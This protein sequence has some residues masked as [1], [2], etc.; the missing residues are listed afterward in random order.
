LNPGAAGVN[1]DG[2]INSGVAGATA[3]IDGGKDTVTVAGSLNQNVTGEGTIFLT[4][5]GT[6]TINGEVD[7]L[8]GGAGDDQ[9]A[10][11][12][13]LHLTN[14]SVGVVNGAGDILDGGDGN[15]TIYGDAVI[16]AS[17]S[18][19]TIN[20]G[21]DSVHGGNGDDLIY[22]EGAPISTSDAI[23][24]IIGGNDI[25]FGDAGNDTIYGQSGNDQLFGGEGDD[26]L[27]GG[28]GNYLLCGGSGTN[29][30]KGGS[31]SDLR[32]AVDDN[33]QVTARGGTLNVSVNE[34]LDDESEGDRDGRRYQILSIS[35]N[36][37]A[38]IDEK[39]GRLT[40]ISADGDGEIE[41]R[42][43][44]IDG[45][46]D[47]AA[48]VFVAFLTTPPPP[49]EP[50]PEPTV[51]PTQA[52]II[53]VVGP[54][55]APTTAPVD[56]TAPEVVPD[57]PVEPT[58][59]DAARLADP[60]EYGKTHKSDS[61]QEFFKRSPLAPAVTVGVAGTVMTSMAGG[62]GMASQSMS[63][64]RGG[65]TSGSSGGA[66]G[67]AEGTSD[68]FA[69]ITRGI[70]PGDR[71]FTW[72]SPGWRRLDAASTVVPHKLAPH[73]PL[74]ARLGIDGSEIR[75]MFGTLW[76]I[77]IGA[78]FY[79]GGLA[80][81]S[82]DG[83]AL[84]PPLW[85]LVA[86]A[87]L[88]TF[89]ALAGAIGSA[90]FIA[91]GVLSGAMVNPQPPDL[92]HS[93]L[94]YC[95]VG[96]L[97]TSIPLIGSAMRPFRRIGKGSV[98]HLWDVMADLA[99]ASLLCA[100]VT[101]G[102]MSSMDSFA[103]QKTGLPEHA[104]LVALVVLSSVALRIITENTATKLYPL[105]LQAV[106]ASSEFPEPTLLSNFGGIALRTGL[107]AFIGHSFVG[108][109]WQFWA[110]TALYCAPQILGA[111]GT[112]FERV[113][114]IQKLMPRGITAL[115]VTLLIAAGVM[116]LVSITT[117]NDLETVRW[118]FMLLAVPPLVFAVLESFTTESSKKTGWAR[119]FLGLGVVVATAWLAFNGWSM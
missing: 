113:D 40:I 88:T 92:V 53:P 86:G 12:G 28:S 81:Y 79:L 5:G 23:D 116:K 37:K 26:I 19:T 52:P 91:A 94:V 69:S 66:V 118:V 85:I 68:R 47:T 15:D 31:G 70:G 46:L 90:I 50:E 16:D 101:R 48:T 60:I 38:V 21:D 7:T 39:T 3:T 95:G 6:G 33:I 2:K 107:F 117:S 59:G 108:N 67:R 114:M 104:N 43:Y 55:E 44:L 77:V 73:S 4:N 96:F 89:D 83:K 17:D 103:G 74:M 8:T 22:G 65:G 57:R 35:P 42:V 75:A 24:L 36:L 58:E 1:G 112:K 105:R 54:T 51:A 76:G 45:G 80:A 71:S 25:L 87:V 102:L 119:E 34:E 41:Y 18:Y 30:L 49:P 111:L 64:A 13:A 27:E 62:A 11:E 109:C 72:R 97:W 63:S 9:L 56:P 61:V 84:P 82:A 78:G 106:E 29:S 93:L 100:W 98:R 110:G 14:G 10:G 99:I 115:L 20:G 32:C